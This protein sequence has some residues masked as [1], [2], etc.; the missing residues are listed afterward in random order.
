M[1]GEQKIQKGTQEKV[2]IDNPYW[3]FNIA[4]LSAAFGQVMTRAYSA[5][6][7]GDSFMMVTESIKHLIAWITRQPCQQ[8]HWLQIG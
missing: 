7:S 3:S 4:I 1:K 5:N 8:N 2:T 6:N